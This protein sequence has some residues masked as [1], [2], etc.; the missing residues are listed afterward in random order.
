MKLL[1]VLTFVVR[2]TYQQMIKYSI[3]LALLIGGVLSTMQTKTAADECKLEREA[4]L[5]HNIKELEFTAGHFTK[6]RRVSAIPQVLNQFSG[7]HL[8]FFPT[9]YPCSTFSFYCPSHTTMHIAL[10]A[11]CTNVCLVGVHWW[12]STWSP[13]TRYRKMRKCG[14]VWYV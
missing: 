2:Y 7:I 8:S 10:P 11:S 13:R 3:I 12:I 5:L 1:R 6:S 9:T 4:V 14:P